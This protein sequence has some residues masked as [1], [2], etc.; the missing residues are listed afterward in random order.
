MRYAYALTGALLLGG[1]AASLALQNPATAQTA[2]NE[3]GSMEASA[4][5]PGAPMSF[6]DMVSKLQPAV[7]NISTDQRVTVA[8]PANPFQGT[9]FADLFGQFGNRGQGGA[10]PGAPPVTR[11][12]QSLGSGFIISADGYVV[13]NNHVVAPGNRQATVEAIRVTLPDR[14]EYVAKLV[15][16]DAASDLALLKI[17]APGP[18]PFVKFGDSTGARVGDWVVAI[19]NPFG[20]GGTVTAGI[21]SAVHRVT[22]QGANDRFIQT[23]ASINQGNSGGPMFNLKGE[24]I[25]INSQIFSQSGGNIG[26]GFA[27]PAEDAKPIIDTL[28]KGQTVQR[29]YIGVS[30]QPLNDDIA[31][32]LNLPKN[33]GEI[34]ARAEPGGPAAKAGVRAGDVVTKVNGKQVTPDTTLSYLVA[35]VPPGQQAR[36]DIIR[37][38]RP[39]NVTVTTATRPPEEQLAQVAGDDDSFSTDDDAAPG[40]PAANGIGVTVQPL[41]PAIARSVG[42]DSTVQGVVIAAVDPSFDAG[43]KLRRGDVIVS[44]N[45]IPARAAADVQRGVAAAKAAGRPQVLLSVVRG[46]NPPVFIAVRIK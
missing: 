1:T 37:D 27:I 22:G 29:G 16:R 32:A 14:K 4:P 5:R 23:D 33:S 45:S 2:Q 26:I 9:P 20:L 6:A 8:Q 40:T 42:V 21:V 15:G 38:G 25:G 44:V 28:M 12:A 30:I 17:T 39:T 13:T 7:V 10:A 3:P 18:L 35:S 34:I 43:Q 46:R 24:V 41:T 36:L 19:G 11:E 31:A